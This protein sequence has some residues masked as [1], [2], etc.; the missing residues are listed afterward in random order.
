MRVSTKTYLLDAANGMHFPDIAPGTHEL[1]SD[2]RSFV[3]DL[4]AVIRKLWGIGG[5]VEFD[6]PRD[7]LTSEKEHSEVGHRNLHGWRRRR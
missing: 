1:N 2:V 7:K 4:V 5:G 6:V 3:D